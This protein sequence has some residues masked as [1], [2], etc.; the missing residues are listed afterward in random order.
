MMASA[1]CPERRAAEGADRERQQPLVES[2]GQHELRLAHAQIL[3]ALARQRRVVRIAGDVFGGDLPDRLD[4]GGRAAAGVLV[5]VQPQGARP[6]GRT[7]VG[8]LQPHL[9]RPRVRLEALL[10]REVV[11][12]VRARVN[13]LAVIR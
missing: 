10:P 2:V 4:H 8:H 5:E 3:R 13:P 6:I 1:V 12:T 7:H 11:T 9:D